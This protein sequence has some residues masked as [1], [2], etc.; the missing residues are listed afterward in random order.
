[1]LIILHESNLKKP[2]ALNDSKQNSAISSRA[3]D[4]IQATTVK[5]IKHGHEHQ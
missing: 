4:T 1:M 5:I 3:T 2:S